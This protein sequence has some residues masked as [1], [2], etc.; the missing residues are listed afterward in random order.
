MLRGQ[1]DDKGSI[2]HS[3]DVEGQENRGNDLNAGGLVSTQARDKPGQGTYF[4]SGVFPG[5]PSKI[6]VELGLPQ[7]GNLTLLLSLSGT[8][9]PHQMSSY[10]I[11]GLVQGAP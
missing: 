10:L 3:R 5:L 7:R 1:E 4:L 9:S 8:P 2:Q 6:P 11:K